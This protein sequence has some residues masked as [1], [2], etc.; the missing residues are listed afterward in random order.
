MLIPQRLINTIRL[1][2]RPSRTRRV[3][4]A[5][6]RRHLHERTG[7][8]AAAQRGLQ[9]PSDPV[10]AKLQEEDGLERPPPEPG[11]PTGAEQEV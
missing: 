11:A 6:E 10:N 3:T 4:Q 1:P 7:R 9:G 5:H 2:R 8:A